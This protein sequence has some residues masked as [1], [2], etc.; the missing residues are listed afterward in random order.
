MKVAAKLKLGFA[1]LASAVLLTG[2]GAIHFVPPGN[3][4]KEIIAN[5]LGYS[6]ENSK[7]ANLWR[8]V[9]D[10]LP[11]PGTE[12]L[13]FKTLK[14]TGS[15]HSELVEGKPTDTTFE[16]TFFNDQD[17]GMVRGVTHEAR[18]GL[19]YSYDLN[20]TYRGLAKLMDRF[21]F[22]DS[23]KWPSLLRARE[24]TEWPSDISKLPEHS[25]FTFAWEDTLYIGTSVDIVRKLKC[26]IGENYPA[27]R[28]MAQVP[29]EAA[30][31]ECISFNKNGVELRKEKFV[32]LRA[33]GLAL[34]LE[35]TSA[36]GKTTRRYETLTGSTNE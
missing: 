21:D 6:A 23:L 27:S 15:I 25:G 5:P 17:N 28:F 30:D 3:P 36:R 26:N 12:V 18:N 11:Q 14:A 20:L 10:K 1:L 35:S 2:C 34:S 24:I 19:P 9:R 7:F 29:G 4:N 13:G 31:V 33:Y 32:F 22:T 16:S 8:S